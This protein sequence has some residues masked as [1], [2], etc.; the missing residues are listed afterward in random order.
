MKV[1]IIGITK[2]LSDYIHGKTISRSL[3]ELVVI[4]MVGVE[5]LI[6][7]SRERQS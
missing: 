4:G 2:V 7:G 3:G 6:K 5:S 1:Q